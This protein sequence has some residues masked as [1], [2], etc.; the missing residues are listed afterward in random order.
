[1]F[2]D[3]NFAELPLEVVNLDDG[4]RQIARLAVVS[5]DSPRP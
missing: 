5:W 2:A 1:L 4:A 3:R